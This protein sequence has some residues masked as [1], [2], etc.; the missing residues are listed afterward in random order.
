MRFMP[1]EHLAKINEEMS[2]YTGI[3]IGDLTENRTK[4]GD[5]IAKEIN[6]AGKTLNVMSQVRKTIDGGIVASHNKMTRL[7]K[8]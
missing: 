2:K 6:E 5:L 1:D 7:R 3:K 4:L 8:S